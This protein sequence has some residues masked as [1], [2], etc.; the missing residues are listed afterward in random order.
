MLWERVAAGQAG[1]ISRRQLSRFGHDRHY[2]RGQLRAR[3]WQE[4]SATVLATTTGQ[5]TREQLAWAGTLH[6]GPGSAVGGLTAAEIHGLKGWQRPAVTVLI[7]E[8]FNLEPIPGVQFVKTRRDIVGFRSPRRRLP[9]WQVEPAMLLFAGY[10]RSSRTAIGVLAAGV[11]QGVTTPDQML[12][13]AARMC[14]LRRAALFREALS[15]MGAGAQS[16]AEIDV[17]RVCRRAGLP[18]PRRQV[19]RT[20]RSGRRHYTDC[21]WDLPDGRV[22]VLEVD[23]AFHMDVDHW[24]ADMARE[25]ELVIG[26][27]IVVRCTARE[28]R[29]HPTRIVRD[30]LALGVTRLSA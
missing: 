25:R 7:G 24:A 30:L 8:S 18:A 28:L 10:T 16:V 12:G 1:L 6:A 11:Q 17:G 19:R 21:E 3:R 23:G 2:V 15:D 22:L 14:P 29:D 9:M 5:L 13:W 20:D 26:G 4:V 27:R